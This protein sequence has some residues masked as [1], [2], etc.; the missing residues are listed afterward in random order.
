MLLSVEIASFTRGI[1]HS[2][3]AL[4]ALLASA[5]V[6]PIV[7]RAEQQGNQDKT[8]PS[9]AS[10]LER[11]QTESGKGPAAPASEPSGP[12]TPGGRSGRPRIPGIVD[13][14]AIYAEEA[15]IHREKPPTGP[16][17]DISLFGGPSATGRSFVFVIDR[18]ASMGSRGL[19]VI[20]AAAEELK[21]SIGRLTDEQTF[22]VVAYN[23]SATF[24]TGRDLI[25]ATAENQ[26]K[27]VR[28]VAS[29]AAYGETQH[30]YGL[31]AA[32]RMKPEVIYLFTDGDPALNVGDLR[33][34]REQAGARTS[35]HCLQFG[36]GQPPDTQPSYQRLARENRGSYLYIDM[37][38][39]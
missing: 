13:E 23:H 4:T 2:G 24:F 38:K 28:F 1:R 31:L 19:G 8:P 27:L 7:V 21:S 37:N 15:S 29:L 5:L 11:L 36:R 18:S 32:I 3:C 22:Q 35:V 16:T 14:A 34:I 17:A 33:L 20:E 9:I 6:G 12:Y 10:V 25:P 26:K 30:M 39:R